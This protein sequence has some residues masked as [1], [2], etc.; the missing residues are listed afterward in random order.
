MKSAPEQITSSISELVKYEAQLF[1]SLNKLK[2]LELEN[3]TNTE[4]YEKETEQSL[5]YSTRE[6]SVLDSIDCTPYQF[7]K[8]FKSIISNLTNFVP[9]YFKDEQTI[10]VK[11]RLL[12]VLGS[13]C[14]K[15]ANKYK[16]FECEENIETMDLDTEFYGND[17]LFEAI[18]NQIEMQRLIKIQEFIDKVDDLEEK[19]ALIEEKFNLLYEN[20]EIHDQLL[21]SSM[22]PY[23]LFIISDDIL[24][25]T[26]KVDK[27]KFEKQKEEQIINN[28]DDMIELS[29]IDKIEDINDIEQ[30]VKQDCDLSFGYFLLNSL[31][32]T[33]ISK[34]LTEYKKDYQKYRKPTHK[35]MINMMNNILKKEC[36]AVSTEL[37]DQFI[38]LI[39][40][41]EI[42][43]EKHKILCELEKQ[44]LKHSP[45][46]EKIKQELTYYL[47]LETDLL[48]NFE[49]NIQE[50]D[51]LTDILDNHLPLLLKNEKNVTAVRK[52][53]GN[54]IPDLID[55]FSA[56]AY[57]EDISYIIHQNFITKT[58]KRLDQIIQ[59]EEDLT[60]KNKLIEEKYLQCSYYRCIN[61]D[62]IETDFQPNKLSI[63][64]DNSI[65][66]L[67]RIH[68]FEYGYDKNSELYVIGNVIL[69]EIISADKKH[70]SI[71]YIL[72]KKI[73]LEEILKG[74]NYENILD[75]EY[76]YDTQI[77]EARQP[78]MVEAKFKVKTLFQ[79]AKTKYLK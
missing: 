16:D 24:I 6:K 60:V 4:E 2:Q 74:I 36:C 43:A 69:H 1:E 21:Q 22:N 55:D 79:N 38:S 33:Q 61:N 67:L 45:E 64:D 50:S 17:D 51:T 76:Q 46:F 58:L 35:L 53:I 68:N 52:R 49:F 70:Q 9:Q 71:G 13:K 42:I 32:T 66:D 75:L 54:M 77:K 78:Q 47:E 25:Q 40:L 41:S 14:K 34:Y 31:S 26:L 28:I 23:F 5:L 57:D 12:R 39:K 11:Q 62:M 20:K 15:L 63:L 72:Y 29:D 10:E 8:S 37:L 73:C 19:A 59:E 30:I 18:H 65:A 44:N 56:V 7:E 3:K 48:D 27:Q